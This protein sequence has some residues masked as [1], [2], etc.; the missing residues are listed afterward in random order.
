MRGTLL[1]LD[2]SLCSLVGALSWFF[3]PSPTFLVTRKVAARS[4]FKFLSNFSY[5]CMIFICTPFKKC[6][7]GYGVLGL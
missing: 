6:V 5:M 4:A 3:V 1:F 7:K 2:C